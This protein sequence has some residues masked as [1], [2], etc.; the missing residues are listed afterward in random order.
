MA[1]GG[2]HF[3][4]M[5]HAGGEGLLPIVIDET[6]AY[7]LLAARE[8]HDPARPGTHDL[9]QSVI[10]LLGSELKRVE[11]TELRDGIFYGQI[12]LERNG[13]EFEVDARPSDALALAARAGCQIL[14][15]E[16]V[17]TENAFAEDDGEGGGSVQA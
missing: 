12:V 3:L 14:V 8:G 9:L 10:T 13:V 15:A 4:V 17:L 1:D 11:V 5:L 7:A 6:Q 16:Q 2:T